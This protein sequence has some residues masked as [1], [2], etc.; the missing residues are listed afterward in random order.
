M[1]INSKTVL[2]GEKVVLVPYKKEHV[3]RY[4][5]WMQS[6]E[7]LEQ[8]ASERLTL[9][10]E[11]DMQNSWFQDENKCTFI[12]LDKRKWLQLETTETECMAGD[13]NLFLDDSRRDVA[14]IEIMIAGNTNLGIQKYEAKIGCSNDASLRLFNKI[15]F[16]EV[17]VSEVF[18]EVTLEMNVT[19]AVQQHLAQAT[20][21]I[22]VHKYPHRPGD[23]TLK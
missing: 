12:I 18:K 5:D 8:T 13:V 14:E 3:P 16:T 11:Y 7:L 1:R 22:H 6:P 23:T 19:E 2:E 10:Q 4:H 21:H 15:G 20:S 9:E 17:S